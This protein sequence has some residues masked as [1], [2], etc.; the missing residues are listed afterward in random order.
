MR[1]WPKNRA[2]IDKIS[3]KFHQR[4]WYCLVANCVSVNNSDT[5]VKHFSRSKHLTNGLNEQF[6]CCSENEK[7]RNRKFHLTCLIFSIGTPLNPAHNQLKCTFVFISE[8][9][10]CIIRCL[11]K[12]KWCLRS[13]GV[14]CVATNRLYH[15]VVYINLSSNTPTESHVP[16]GENNNGLRQEARHCLCA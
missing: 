7:P 11:C 9:I 16:T 3:T 4:N 8:L 6:V 2:Q 14:V 12:M 1:F 15:D 13:S 10:V 5:C